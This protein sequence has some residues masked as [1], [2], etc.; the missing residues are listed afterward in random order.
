[1]RKPTASAAPSSSHRGSLPA[2]LRSGQDGPQDRRGSTPHVGRG[3]RDGRPPARGPVRSSPVR[4]GA[5][6]HAPACPAEGTGAVILRWGVKDESRRGEAT[7]VAGD[8]AELLGSA[9]RRAAAGP[10][11]HG[12]SGPRDAICCVSRPGEQGL[13][14]LRFCHVAPPWPCAAPTSL[15]RD[16]PL[17]P[18]SRCRGPPASTRGGTTLL[19]GSVRVVL[20][21]G[22]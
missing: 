9:A 12:L 16:D 2:P 3:Y 15:Q 10:A 22:G 13:H 6:P 17:F 20:R 19:A 8:D 5:L 11:P 18:G 4:S 1:M 7:A 21:L 14:A